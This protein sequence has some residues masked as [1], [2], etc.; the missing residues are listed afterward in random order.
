MLGG[1][2]FDGE[3]KKEKNLW[4]SLFFIFPS[5]VEYISPAVSDIRE[6]GR[7]FTTKVR[8]SPRVGSGDEEKGL[9]AIQIGVCLSLTLPGSYLLGFKVPWFL[10]HPFPPYPFRSFFFFF[11]RERACLT[12]YTTRTVLGPAKNVSGSGPSDLPSRGLSD[13]KIGIYYYAHTGTPPHL[14]W[15]FPW[16][17]GHGLENSIIKHYGLVRPCRTVVPA[18]RYPKNVSRV[19]RALFRDIFGAKIRRDYGL[20]I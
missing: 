5:T 18:F 8:P 20:V 15:P 2:G 16:T 7:V 13:G 17:H 1:G 19:A 6:R 11:L 4:I 10:F 12:F 14:P 3:I 9:W